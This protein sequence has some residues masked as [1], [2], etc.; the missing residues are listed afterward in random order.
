[1]PTSPPTLSDRTP[2]T[3][4]TCVRVQSKCPYGKTS[5]LVLDRTGL[6]GLLRLDL[7]TDLVHVERLDLTDQIVECVAGKGAWLTK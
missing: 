3:G 4:G 6:L 2:G 5:F 7:S 1:M